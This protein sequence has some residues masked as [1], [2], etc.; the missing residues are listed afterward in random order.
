MLG[1]V[2]MD[3]SGVGISQMV[4]ATVYM[5]LNSKLIVTV[6]LPVVWMFTRQLNRH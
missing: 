5:H 6:F 4:Y 1:R 3:P 2:P